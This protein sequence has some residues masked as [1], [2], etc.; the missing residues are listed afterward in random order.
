MGTAEDGTLLV[1]LNER[2]A[3]EGVTDLTDKSA[4]VLQEIIQRPGW[5]SQG[6]RYVGPERLLA[7][8]TRSDLAIHAEIYLLDA[9]AAPESIEVSYRGGSCEVCQ[10][11]MGVR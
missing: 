2:V 6:M 7:A 3:E 8:G 9:G 10:A 5:A 4:Q 11:I 1:S